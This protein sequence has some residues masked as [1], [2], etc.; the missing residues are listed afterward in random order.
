M[1]LLTRLLPGTTTVGATAPAHQGRW[2]PGQCLICHAWPAAAA[3]ED[4]SARFIPELARCRRCAA[5]L[6]S[7]A[8]PVCGAC[9]RE[10]PP[11]ER[12]VVA[13]SYGWPWQ[14]W[15]SQFKFRDDTGLAH[16]MAALMAAAPGAR[17]LLDA[18]DALVPLPL[19]PERL[20]ERGYNQALL[21]AR[22]LAPRKTRADLLLRAHHTVPQHDL[23]R[24]QRLKSLRGAF[25]VEPLRARVVAGRRLLLVDDVVTTGATLHAAARALLEAGAARVDAL[26]FAHT[27]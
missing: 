3:C 11:L 20:A 26:A 10:P 14:S 16:P 19:T 5:P 1:G 4:C 21:L 18:A 25:L 17:E 24:A 7:A 23:P 13:V 22:R 12:C 27:D 8:T 15:V 2:L 9:L 6:A